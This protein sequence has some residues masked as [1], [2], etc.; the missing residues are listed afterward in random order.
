M[1]RGK[2]WRNRGDNLLGVF[3]DVLSENGGGFQKRM[4][5][6]Q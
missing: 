2:F 6:I 5:L 4:P 3:A 1:I